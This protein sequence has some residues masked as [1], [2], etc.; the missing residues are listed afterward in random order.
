MSVNAGLR[1]DDYVKTKAFVDILHYRKNN[2]NA[3][4]RVFSALADKFQVGETQIADIVFNKEDI[5]KHGF[6]MEMTNVN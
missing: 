4:T 6:K 1:H 5:I 2:G 3:G